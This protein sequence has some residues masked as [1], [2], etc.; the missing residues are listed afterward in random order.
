MKLFKFNDKILN[1]QACTSIGVNK[2]RLRIVFNLSHSIEMFDPKLSKNI[3]VADYK[4]WDFDN[5]IDF[6]AGLQKVS[7]L[8][9][10]NE[11]FISSDKKHYFVN[12]DQLSYI[13]FDDDNN[14]IIFNLSTSVTK[15]TTGTLT[16]DY[17]F[18]TFNTKD[19]YLDNIKHIEVRL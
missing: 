2:S 8:I 5:E 4:Y 13:T 12:P 18:W 16:N 6:N 17:V 10:V 19:E 14:R 7:S 9:K 11:F 15:K 3:I 1:L